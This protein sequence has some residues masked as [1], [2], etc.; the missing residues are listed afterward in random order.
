MPTSRRLGSLLK[1]R[2]RAATFAEGVEADPEIVA[3]ETEAMLVAAL[4]DSDDAAQLLAD[5]A[6]DAHDR[7]HV[8]TGDGVVLEAHDAATVEAAQR[9]TRARA[10]AALGV[11]AFAAALLLRRRHP[12]GRR[13]PA[14]VFAKPAG[15][16]PGQ[17]WMVSAS[18]MGL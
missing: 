4:D 11:M 2:S 17:S 12:R 10:A 5:A 6:E 9:G 1:R 14:R 18:T 8:T 3:R 16:P 7:D 13:Q 15:A